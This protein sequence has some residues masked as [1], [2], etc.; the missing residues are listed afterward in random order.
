MLNRKRLIS[1][2]FKISVENEKKVHPVH[3]K[4]EF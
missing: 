2:Q 4:P 3:Q 1:G